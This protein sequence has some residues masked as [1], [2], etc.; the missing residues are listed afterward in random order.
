MRLRFVRK[1]F[2]KKKKT[3]CYKILKLASLVVW[4]VGDICVIRVT[5]HLCVI[6]ALLKNPLTQIFSRKKKTNKTIYINDLVHQS[7]ANIFSRLSCLSCC[8]MDTVLGGVRAWGDS[9]A[10]ALAEA[11]WVSHLQHGYGCDS[12]ILAACSKHLPPWWHGEEAPQTSQMTQNNSNNSVLWKITRLRTRLSK[13]WTKENYR[14]KE[15]PRLV[16]FN[17]NCLILTR[18]SST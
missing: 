17:W 14:Q 13:R 4:I 16:L 2:H 9:E 10:V 11:I 6:K 5:L 3:H 1:Y 18:Q 7:Q 8:I 12:S 15:R